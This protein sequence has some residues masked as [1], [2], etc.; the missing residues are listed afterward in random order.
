MT[1]TKTNT[2]TTGHRR[3]TGGLF[4]STAL[5]GFTRMAIWSLAGSMAFAATAHA[6][7]LPTGGTVAA[8]SATIASGSNATTIKQNSQSAVLN[9]DSFNIAAGKS[10]RFDQP[11]KSS[12]ALNRVTG[13]D[14]STILGN[15]SANG[16]VFLVNPN[17]VLFGKGSQ[18]SVG[19]LVAS[20]LNISDADFMA[21][22]YAFSGTSTAAVLNQGTIV[23]A[24]QGYV[25]LLGANVG[26]TGVIKARLGTVALAAG[27][28]I[29]MDVAGD[30]LLNITIDTGAMN[31]LVT[32]G[33]LIRADGGDVLLTAQAAG[34][35]LHTVVNN[36]GVI[37]ART[38]Y[39]R[40]GTIKL[41]G[42]MTN[43]RLG[44][45]GTLDASAPAG[46]D[47]GFIETSAARVDIADSARITTVAPKGTTG[48]WLIDPEDFVVS[49]NGNITG[50]RLSALLVTNNV[51]ISTLPGEE[52]VVPGTPPT[53][54]IGTSAPGNGDI[55]VEDAI[56]WVA[57][58]NTTTLRLNAIRDIT[59]NGAITAT[60]GNV[61][62]CCG[63]DI[64]V[65]SAITTTNGSVLLNAGRNLMVN[66]A[67]TTTNGNITL[68]AGIDVRMNAKLTLT[69]T[70]AILSQSLDL[71]P[72]LHIVS[73]TSG[74]G[75]G[76]AGGTVI[77]S[78]TAPDATVT[79][80]PVLIDYNPISY[81]APSDYS[82]NF[83]LT[84]GARVTQRMLLF[85]GAVKVENGSTA[86]TLVGFNTNAASGIPEGVTLEAGP[87]SPTA[88]T[89]WPARTPP[90]TRSPARA[91]RPDS[92]PPARSRL[93]RSW[94]LRSNRPSSC[95][96]SS[97]QWSCRLSWCRQW[98]FRQ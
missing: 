57:A 24:D 76:V 15:L 72:G 5:G 6:Q 81:A 35:L 69:G 80:A 4:G 2:K 46:G 98:S 70:A 11:G 18:V 44:V 48:T 94:F 91:A 49:A 53:T 12:V 20:T 83:I 64:N 95:R 47:G 78:P 23:A 96:L 60:N 27:Q 77:F 89:C 17:G 37:E 65:N 68:C 3:M 87:D 74:T 54:N 92:G 58:P 19:G 9:W 62:A 86:A 28:G 41:L 33:G 14:A 97:L 22:R 10:V 88:A 82:D 50:A 25:A 26:N 90:A 31:A 32:N 61:V 59:I 7:S 43:G 63:R 71:T 38:I 85:P 34:R 75:P 79:N 51:T 36:T 30:G 42:D 52:V 1:R 73:G 21:G 8:G 45:G 13:G 29:T 39:S 84:E 66:A 56:S 55:V 67:M 93:H 40:D 16:K